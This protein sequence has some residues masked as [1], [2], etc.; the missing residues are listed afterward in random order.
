MVGIY[1]P[2]VGKS[3][4]VLGRERRREI[5]VRHFGGKLPRANRECDAFRMK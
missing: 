4:V 2:I 5:D 1:R 3:P